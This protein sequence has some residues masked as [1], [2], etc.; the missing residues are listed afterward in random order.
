[1]LKEKTEALQAAADRR[2]YACEDIAQRQREIHCGEQNVLEQGQLLWW[3]VENLAAA[4]A[5]PGEPPTSGLTRFGGNPDEYL[6][7]TLENALVTARRAELMVWKIEGNP[8]LWN[9]PYR[10]HFKEELEALV[11]QILLVRNAATVLEADRRQLATLP[12]GDDDVEQDWEIAYLAL[13]RALKA[14]GVAL[15]ALTGG[16]WSVVGALLA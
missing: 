1:M 12:T 9:A 7:P 5:R 15:P 11:G 16:A 8:K 3:R 2:E 4:L 10:S 6:K 13:K 14:D